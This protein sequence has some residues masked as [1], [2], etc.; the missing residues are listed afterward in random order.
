MSSET[1]GRPYLTP[2]GEN[3]TGTQPSETAAAT[4]R[5]AERLANQPVK[6]TDA[7]L[8]ASLERLLGSPLSVHEKLMFPPEGGFYSVPD[9]DMSRLSDCASGNLDKAVAAVELA[10]TPASDERLGKALAELRVVT[11][12]RDMSAEDVAWQAHT[13]LRLLADWPADVALE[14]LREWPSRQNGRWWPTWHELE[15]ILRRKAS[16]R[17][18]LLNRLRQERDRR[19]A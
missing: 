19:A 15:A 9:Y 18:A 10:C 13:Y 14:V 11:V 16:S 6:H 4:E 8:S 12:G 7:S 2:V 17:K 5:A 1:T 3:W